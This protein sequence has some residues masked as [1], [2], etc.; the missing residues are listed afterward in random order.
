MIIEADILMGRDK[1]YPLSEGLKTNLRCL[2]K[3]IKILE[4][5]CPHEFKVSSG[6]RPPAINAKV[7]GAALNSAHAVCMAVDL[8]DK[9]GKIDQWCLDNLN[10]LEMLG[11]Y[12]EDPKNTI[13]WCHL[14]TRAPKSGKRVFKP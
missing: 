13:G 4:A 14:T 8:V 5:V 7:A 3:V 10:K 9:D 11:L 12:L 6:Y 1:A 2:V